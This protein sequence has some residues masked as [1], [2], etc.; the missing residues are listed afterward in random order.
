MSSIDGSYK[1]LK[2]KAKEKLG[3]GKTSSSGK[4]SPAQVPRVQEDSPMEDV[5]RCPRV[6][7][8]KVKRK[9]TSLLGDLGEM[10]VEG[11]AIVEEE[12]RGPI[13]HPN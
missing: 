4:A 11:G 13:L 6:V 8:K 1:D 3:L 12:V 9:K 10:D 5:V 2:G 7:V